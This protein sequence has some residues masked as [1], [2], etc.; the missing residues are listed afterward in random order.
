MPAAKSS[1]T[2]GS[3]QLWL[4]LEA[5]Q[6]TKEG[7]LG[8]LALFFFTPA[9]MLVRSGWGSALTATASV[10]NGLFVIPG[11]AHHPGGTRRKRLG[12]LNL[13]ATTAEARATCSEL[14]Y[15]G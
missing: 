1:W 13:V 3:N 11:T 4:K 7:Q 14:Q 5:A 15:L 8:K 9:S 2:R 12:G 10:L 6:K